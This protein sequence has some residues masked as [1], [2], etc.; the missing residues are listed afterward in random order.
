MPALFFCAFSNRSAVDQLNP[1]CIRAFMAIAAVRTLD[2]GRRKQMGKLSCGAL[3]LRLFG[4]GAVI[5]V[6]GIVAPTS[7][8][9]TAATAR[10][11]ATVPFDGEIADFYRS[12][13]GAPLWFAPGAGPA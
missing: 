5:A 7:F 6:L 12:R 2:Q 1:S 9:P 10:S 8:G 4:A 13:G 11:A 3:P